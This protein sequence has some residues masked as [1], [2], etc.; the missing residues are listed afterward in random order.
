MPRRNS[1]RKFKPPKDVKPR[2]G[3]K[4]FKLKGETYDNGCEKCCS[5]CYKQVECEGNCALIDSLCVF[6]I[7]SP[8]YGKN[9]N[10]YTV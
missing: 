5:K 9:L 3:N 10:K 1:R 4:K 8:L 2:K 6:C 7:H